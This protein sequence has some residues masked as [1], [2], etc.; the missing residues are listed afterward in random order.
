MRT[1][2]LFASIFEPDEK[3]TTD[4]LFSILR[5]YLDRFRDRLSKIDPDLRLAAFF[6]LIRSSAR[7]SR[8]DPLPLAAAAES[9]VEAAAAAA[10]A[11]SAVDSAASAAAASAFDSA[12]AAS[13]AASAAA[14]AAASATAAAAASAAAA[15][16]AA[17]AAAACLQGLSPFP[18]MSYKHIG[19]KNNCISY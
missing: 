3:M 18:M 17:T 15:A 7:P 10:A 13:A 9:N 4:R 6:E 16:A 14:A 12:S 19:V 11:A 1:R 5:T 8:N 2:G